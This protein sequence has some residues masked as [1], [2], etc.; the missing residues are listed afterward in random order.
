M[1]KVQSKK[2][3]IAMSKFDMGHLDS[4]FIAASIGFYGHIEG[5]IL[6][7]FQKDIAKKACSMLIG[8]DDV[9]DGDV[10]DSVGELINITMGKAKTVLST[11]NL[12]I[13]MTLP[14]TFSSIGEIQATFKDKDGV[15]ME[16]SFGD[17]QFMF[18]LTI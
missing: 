14:R 1:T 18:F 11:K 6:L 7:M 10:L 16:F 13:K 3:S 9:K 12:T 8:S 15:L 4:E 17:Q 2:L 5:V